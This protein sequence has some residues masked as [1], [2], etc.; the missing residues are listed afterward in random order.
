[1]DFQNFKFNFLKIMKN[2]A[3]YKTEFKESILRA[4]GTKKK[5]C[6]W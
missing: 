1:M 4:W 2:N 6:K 5:E 3:K